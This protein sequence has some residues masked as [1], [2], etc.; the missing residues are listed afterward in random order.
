MR[1]TTDPDYEVVDPEQGIVIVNDKDRGGK[2]SMARLA[3]LDARARQQLAYY[4]A[5]RSRLVLSRGMGPKALAMS[6]PIFRKDPTWRV[7]PMTLVDLVQM[8]PEFPGTD[9]AF[10]KY[11]HTRL[12]E[13]GVPGEL[14][15]AISGHWH[16]GIE[17]HS[18]FSAL[19]PR[20]L[21]DA[22]RQP[23]ATLLTEI[24]FEPL[25]SRLP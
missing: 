20:L 19:C 22:V 17:A 2:R 25:R 12:S 1:G 8:A 16:P 11:A 10:R 4:E 6:W 18:R 5:H 13:L 9:N 15:D 7:V 14:L 24:G 21:V 23:L 3:L